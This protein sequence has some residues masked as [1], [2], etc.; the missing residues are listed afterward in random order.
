LRKTS[1]RRNFTIIIFN[2]ATIEPFSVSLGEASLEFG[3]KF[4]LAAGDALNLASAIRQGAD[5]FT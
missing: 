4:G 2:L 3:K 1:R 5:E